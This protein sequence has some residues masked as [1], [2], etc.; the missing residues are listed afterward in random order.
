MQ[1]SI[2]TPEALKLQIMNDPHSPAQFRV[3][4]TLSNSY[5]FAQQFKCKPN[6]RMNPDADKK[7]V[8]W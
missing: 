6:S 2:G 7:C 3:I 8:V 5:E 4:G 1:S